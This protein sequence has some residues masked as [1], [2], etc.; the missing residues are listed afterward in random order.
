VNQ[1]VAELAAFWYAFDMEQ[2]KRPKVGI[3]VMVFK[4]GRILLGKRK[5]S[6]GAGEYA[7]PGGHMEYMES[8]E[9]CAKRELLEETGMQITN[10]RFLRLLNLKDYAPKHYVDVGLIADWESGEPLV[11]EPNKCEGWDWYDLKN[12]PAPLFK[13]TDTYLEALE[14]GKNYYD[15]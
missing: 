12:L 8:F 2:D 11:L 4:E 7:I 10:I 1:E 3:G 5:G 6:H 15:A 13:T 14:T 9:A